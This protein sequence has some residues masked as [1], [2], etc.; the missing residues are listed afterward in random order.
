MA[1]SG[2][3]L[4]AAERRRLK[5]GVWMRWAWAVGANAPLIGLPLLLLHAISRRS[6]TP[7]LLASVLALPPLLIQA[8]LLLVGGLEVI[9][10]LEDPDR[11]VPELQ[12]AFLAHLPLHGWL[13]ILSSVLGSIGH[14]VGQDRDLMATRRRCRGAGL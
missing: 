10:R 9:Q 13:S 1:E 8:G 3:T 6:L 5:D 2:A 4:G 12:V 14:K 7:M 11:L